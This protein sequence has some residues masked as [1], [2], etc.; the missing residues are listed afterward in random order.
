ML[1]AEQK[2][3]FIMEDCRLV[4]LALRT[5]TSL[6]DRQLITIGNQRFLLQ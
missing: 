2:R 6:H 4:E 3:H 1:F 5:A